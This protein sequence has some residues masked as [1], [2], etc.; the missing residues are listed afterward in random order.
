MNWLICLCDASYM[1]YDYFFSENLH[2]HDRVH[3][4]MKTFSFMRTIVL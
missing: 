4:Q 3:F 2:L 1:Q